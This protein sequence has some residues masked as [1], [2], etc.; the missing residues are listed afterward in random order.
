MPSA[1]SSKKALYASLSADPRVFRVEVERIVQGKKSY[2]WKV[3]LSFIDGTF[4]ALGH[5]LAK[6][7]RGSG[8]VMVITGITDNHEL[9]LSYE[10]ADAVKKWAI[11]RLLESLWDTARR[12]LQSQGPFVDVQFELPIKAPTVKISITDNSNQ[13]RSGPQKGN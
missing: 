9:N 4:V 13:T 11:D 2:E 6:E 3:Q 8:Q 5:L 7:E 12:T 1:V 10:S